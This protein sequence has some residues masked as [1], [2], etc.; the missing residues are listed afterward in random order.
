[1]VYSGIVGQGT[2]ISLAFQAGCVGNEVSFFQCPPLNRLH[3]YGFYYFYD[4]YRYDGLYYY[5]CNEHKYDIGA[6]CESGMYRVN[7]ILCVPRV[8]F[9]TVSAGECQ[10]GDVRLANGTRGLETIEGRVEICYGGQW[11][12]VGADGQWA[13][14]LREASVVCR[15]LHYAPVALKAF[16]YSRYGVGTGRVS[17]SQ[18]YCIGYESKLT[19]CYH[20]APGYYDYYSYYAVAVRC[21]GKT[22]CE[23]YWLAGI[24][25]MVE[26]TSVNIFQLILTFTFNN[27][28]VLP[29]MPR[30]IHSAGGWELQL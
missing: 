17:F 8:C 26:W 18:T 27:C 4:Y 9:G 10:D 19:D 24:E 21:Q 22:F 23:I 12:V 6:R 25:F 7:S 3:Y 16:T 14:T 5:T 20:S 1:M 30:W 28:S 15:Q 29:S 13:W 2:G 11:G